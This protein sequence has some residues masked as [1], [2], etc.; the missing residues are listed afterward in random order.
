[1]PVAPA[2]ADDPPATVGTTPQPSR[3]RERS[4]MGLAWEPGRNGHSQGDAE[5]FVEVVYGRD[6]ILTVHLAASLQ[7]NEALADALMDVIATSAERQ[8]A[9]DGIEGLASEFGLAVQPIQTRREHMITL[10]QPDLG[11]ESH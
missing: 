6:T 3:P 2:V 7:R 4:D 10:T 8:A 9:E 5:Q 11:S 1:M